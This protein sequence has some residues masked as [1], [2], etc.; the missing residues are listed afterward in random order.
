MFADWIDLALLERINMAHFDDRV[1]ISSSLPK[2]YGIAAGGNWVALNGRWHNG[3]LSNSFQP[4]AAHSII[5][6]IKKRER[7]KVQLQFFSSGHACWHSVPA[8]LFTL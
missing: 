3:E 5:K 7:G 1:G 2:H 6:I 4:L 8:G